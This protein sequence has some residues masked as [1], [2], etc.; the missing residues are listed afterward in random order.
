MDDRRT[1]LVT[2]GTRGIGE[3]VA[4]AL[5]AQGW[6]VLAGSASQAEIDAFA[7]DPTIET[8]LVDVTSDASVADAMARCGRLDGLVNCAGIL[9]R[10]GAEF[11]MEAFEKT[12]SVNLLGTMRMCLAAR[13]RLAERGGAIVN[14]GSMY[15]FFG[16]PH[17]PAYAASKGGVAQL[18]KSLAVAWAPEGVRVN[19]VAPGWIETPLTRPAVDDPARSAAIVGRTP[20]GRWGAPADVAGAVLFLLSDAARFVTGTVLPVDGGYAVA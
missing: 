2:G 8:V 11:T 17:A 12:V 9:M 5:A 10:G 15:S 16:A 18:T 1:A 7:P 6:R 13:P 19:A 3:G 20:M 14:L 4:R